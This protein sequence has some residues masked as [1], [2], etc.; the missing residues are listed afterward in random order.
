MRA[1]QMAAIWDEVF[2]AA[3]EARLVTVIST[4]TGWP[5]RERALLDAPDWV[6]EDPHRNRRPAGRFDAYGVT[7]YFDTGLGTDGKAPVVLSW[8]RASREAAQAEAEA[9]GLD[10]AAREA[11]VAA[12]RYDHAVALAA[13]ELRD[14]SVTGGP[15]GSATHLLDDL[16]PHHAD[17]AAREGLDLVM[18][19]GGTHVVGRGRWVEDAE[20]TDFFIHLNYAPEMARLY[21]TVLRGWREVGGTMFNAYVDVGGPSKWGSWGALRHLDDANP[22]WDALTAFNRETEVWWEERGP[23][24]FTH[25][26]GLSGEGARTTGTIKDDVLLGG[27]RDDRLV[28]HG[29]DDRL[30]GGGG[31]DTAVLPGRFGEHSF[32]TEGAALLAAG[33]SGVTRLVEVETLV[34][35]EEPDRRVA[36][37]DLP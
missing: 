29:G 32:R 30:H 15:E 21:E 23:A 35:A 17:V 36:V 37:S 34:F 10:G 14:G 7:G 2:G 19:E 13:R 4:Q 3:A 26:V 11:H 25:G 6:A 24:A 16:L 8:L 20:L 9:R 31:D 12:H 22:R 33:P 5:G 18:Y 1:A 28:G 27:P